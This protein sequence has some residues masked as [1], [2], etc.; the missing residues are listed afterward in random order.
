MSTIAVPLILINLNGDG[1]HL[2]V[3]LRAFGQK[4][5]AVIDTGASTSVFDRNF[6]QEYVPKTE[7]LDAVQTVTLFTTSA[8]IHGI[9]PKLKIG[10]LA[11]KN[12]P[13]V[14]LDLD[15]VNAAYESHGHPRIVAIL[16]GDIF[17]NYQAKINYKKLKIYFSSK[18]LSAWPG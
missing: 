10:K 7:E 18:P 2:L 13:V 14:A 12:Y 16:G 4:Q 9:V 6:I 11:I 1:F 15:S 5:F 8:S 3:E 17:Y